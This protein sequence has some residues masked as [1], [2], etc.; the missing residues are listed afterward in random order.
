MQHVQRVHDQVAAVGLEDGAGADL[1]EIRVHDAHVCAPF[2]F[3]DQVGVRRM[4]FVDDGRAG[5]RV[6]LDDEIHEIAGHVRPAEFQAGN[7]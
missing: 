3:A 2:D 5:S 1:G 6:M 7:G 4:G